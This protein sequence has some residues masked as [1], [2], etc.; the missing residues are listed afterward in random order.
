MSDSIGFSRGDILHELESG[1]TWKVLEVPAVSAGADGV[2]VMRT[3]GRDSDGEQM[4]KDEDEV[5]DGQFL[6]MI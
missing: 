5:E 1:V 6:R 4:T 3:Y 2:Y